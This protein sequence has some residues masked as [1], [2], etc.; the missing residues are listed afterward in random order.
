MQDASY[1]VAFSRARVGNDPSRAREPELLRSIPPCSKRARESEIL[2]DFTRQI[3]ADEFL[4]VMRE[5]VT[6]SK[7]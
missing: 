6:L 7:A 1:R 2:S 3:D 5:F 4:V